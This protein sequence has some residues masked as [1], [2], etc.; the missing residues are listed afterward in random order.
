MR[1]VRP[2]HYLYVC[3]PRSCLIAPLDARPNQAEPQR[4][5]KQEAVRGK[6]GARG[7]L[8]ANAT[9]A[10]TRRRSERSRREEISPCRA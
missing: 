4:R 1:Q 10:S 7:L 6:V 3:W 2:Q 9:R 8:G 5:R